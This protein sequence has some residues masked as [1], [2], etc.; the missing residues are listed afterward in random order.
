[1]AVNARASAAAAAAGAAALLS[2]NQMAS[3][4]AAKACSGQKVIIAWQ[5]KDLVVGQCCPV[6]RRP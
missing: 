6:C 5:S 2:P 1:M 4:A 3:A